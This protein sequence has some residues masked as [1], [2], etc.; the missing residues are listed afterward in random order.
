LVVKERYVA[1][2]TVLPADG[3]YIP[4]G[5]ASGDEIDIH[6]GFDTNPSHVPFPVGPSLYSCFDQV[7]KNAFATNPLMLNYSGPFIGLFSP[8][9]FSYV[10]L[11]ERT[12]AT[13]EPNTA[14]LA[15]GGALFF[16]ICRFLCSGL[17][18]LLAHEEQ[19]V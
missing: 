12:V 19:R 14:L 7:C 15:L 8:G 6:F 9:S 3:G 18:L 16:L 2:N 10:D 5:P 13:P 4:T 11:T 1:V 17:Q